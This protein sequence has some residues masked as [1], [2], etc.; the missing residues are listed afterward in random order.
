MTILITGGAGFIGTNICLE[1]IKRGYKVIAMDSFIRPK[2][3]ENIPILQEAGVE[4]LR[5]DVRQMVDFHRSPVPDAI[6]HLAGNPGIP[7]SIR[8]PVYDFQ[9]N[10]QG[11]LNVLE[12]ARVMGVQ[13]N[14]KIPVIYA[15]TNKVYTDLINEIPLEEKEKRYEWNLLDLMVFKYIAGKPR[16][17]WIG[18]V[19]KKGIN[20][21]FPLDGFGKYHH[22]PYGTSKL[23]GDLYCQEYFHAFEIP[24]VINRMSCIY[25]YYQK[26]VQDQGWIDHFIRRIAFGNGKLNFFGDGKQVRD[27]LWGEDV[28]RLY[29]DEL[30]S[31]E[32][33]K[34]QIFNI[35]GGPEN[36]MSLIE[37]VEYIEKIS[38]KK[39]EIEY[40][41]WRPA[42]QRVYISDISKV[43]RIL[44]WEPKISPREGI[45]KI[46]DR[47]CQERERN[48]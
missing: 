40:H 24:V 33:V 4:I 10:A 46:Y 35:G 37:A 20:E 22:S 42:D 2:S 18:G 32:K 28:A 45:K 43:K 1:A 34:G 19:T 38:G 39:A 30:E 36:T 26:G 48:G 21:T 6:I 9:V 25:G 7:W 5:G 3:E 41:D 47:Y 14:K 13:M 8:W 15:S 11:T 23:A 16:P 17:L 44:G 27:M 29:L 31:M 12:Y